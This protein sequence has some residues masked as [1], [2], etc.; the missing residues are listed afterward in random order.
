[1]M[2]F[3]LVGGCVNCAIFVSNRNY[4]LWCQFWCI[5]PP[6]Y[7][8]P[9][10]KL[11][12][13]NNIWYHLSFCIMVSNSRIFETTRVNIFFII[14]NSD[15]SEDIAPT[16]WPYVYTPDLHRCLVKSVIFGTVNNPTVY[17][18]CKHETFLESSWT[19]SRFE[20]VTRSAHCTKQ[21]RLD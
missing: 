10:S 19:N 4:C 13:Q 21:S 14:V 5:W 6:I 16:L 2:T 7:M 20:Q 11:I 8:K 3:W 12:W 9:T 1:M 18:V 15:K 17:N